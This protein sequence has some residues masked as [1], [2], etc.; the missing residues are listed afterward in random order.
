M[1]LSALWQECGA[2]AESGDSSDNSTLEGL[3]RQVRTFKARKALAVKREREKHKALQCEQ[4]DEMES[5]KRAFQQQFLCNASVQW[6]PFE[7]DD[8]SSPAF[9][10]NAGRRRAVYLY[11]KSFAA[12][13]KR[14]FQW[15]PM[16]TNTAFQDT[17][18]PIRHLISVNTNDDTNIKVGSGIHGST[19]VRSVMN[20]IQEHVVLTSSAPP[21]WFCLHQ[22]IVAL[23]RADTSGLYYAFMAWVLG[24]AGYVGWRL[25]VWGIPTNILRTV[26]HQT[27]IFVGDALR[28]NDAIFKKL[29]Q[30]VQCA[31]TASHVLQIH[32]SIHQ[33]SLTRKTLALGFP[34]YWSNLV[35][36]GHL[37]ESHTFRQRFAA[38]MSKVIQEN[39]EFIQVLAPPEDSISWKRSKIAGLQL[40]QDIGHMGL[41]GKNCGRASPRLKTLITLLQKDNGDPYG[42]TFTHWCSGHGCCPGGRDE[43]L[44]GMIK[45]YLTLFSHAPVPLLYR[46]KHASAANTFM[47]D[48]F[49][50]H[51]VL[52]RTLQE[53][54]TLKC[55]LS[56]KH[57]IFSYYILSN[58]IQYT[59][60]SE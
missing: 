57:I 35:R 29:V 42:D 23:D 50:L 51:R 1:P 12:A 32:C 58:T 37:F 10:D 27:C 55:A 52:P 33:V 17:K 48:G 24:F 21:K 43:A 30:C 41:G 9:D 7:G 6:D 22:P 40:H 14:L 34:G 2:E 38:C 54:P 4:N 39:F 56:N 13:V 28:V 20:N 45:S 26:R 5:Q 53:M 19:E 25:R 46:W 3:R 49:F 60:Y 36:L 18:Q 59:V 44:T 8:Q 16:E 31:A 11:F 15:R 47:R